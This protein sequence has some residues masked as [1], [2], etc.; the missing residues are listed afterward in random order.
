MADLAV[1]AQLHAAC[2]EVTPELDALIAQR[3][4]LVDYMK[5]VEQA[6]GG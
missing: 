1:Y 5:R 3:P 6:T 2:G 4:G